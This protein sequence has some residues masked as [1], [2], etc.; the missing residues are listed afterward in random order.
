M[1]FDRLQGRNNSE[2][3]IKNKT[4]EDEVNEEE[5]AAHLFVQEAHKWQ[6]LHHGEQQQ[7]L[8]HDNRQGRAQGPE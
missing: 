4:A 3:Q 1:S 8:G 5:V 6:H 7:P 2:P